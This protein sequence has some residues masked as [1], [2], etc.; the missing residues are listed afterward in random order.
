MP[1]VRPP[2]VFHP[3][4]RFRHQ[5][6]PRLWSVLPKCCSVPVSE[7]RARCGDRAQPAHSGSVGP[8]GMGHPRV[9]TV[10]LQGGAPALN[11]ANEV[12]RSPGELH[13]ETAEESE[14]ALGKLWARSTGRNE[15]SCA[16][17]T[18]KPPSVLDGHHPILLLLRATRKA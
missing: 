4:P 9:V 18:E 7:Q 12:R 11:A 1:I 8:A 10:D 2:T 15:Q 14:L 17:S 3:Q 16:R 6:S 5:I 13:T